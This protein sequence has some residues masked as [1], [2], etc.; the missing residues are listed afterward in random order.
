MAEEKNQERIEKI[1]KL[2]E[3]VRQSEDAPEVLNLG[4][5]KET[6]KEDDLPPEEA[7]LLNDIMNLSSGEE[8]YVP[9][10]EHR[11]DVNRDREADLATFTWSSIFALTNSFFLSNAAGFTGKY[12]KNFSMKE[13]NV[14]TEMIYKELKKD[15]ENARI[16]QVDEEAAKRRIIER[17]QNGTEGDKRR[18][19]ISAALSDTIA[20]TSFPELSEELSKDPVNNAV[21]NVVGVGSNLIKNMGL[22]ILSGGSLYALAAYQ[23]LDSGVSMYNTMAEYK[24]LSNNPE[25]NPAIYG[26]SAGVAASLSIGLSEQFSRLVFN[27]IL[28]KQATSLLT[29][30][31]AGSLRESSEYI[32]EHFIRNAGLVI[33][34]DQEPLDFNTF[35]LATSF[36]MGGVLEVGRNQF[37]LASKKHDQP[38][39][40]IA[41][42]K[43][44]ENVKVLKTKESDSFATKA[45]RELSDQAL[46]RKLKRYMLVQNLP[47]EALEGLQKNAFNNLIKEFDESVDVA[48]IDHAAMLNNLKR[49]NEIDKTLDLEKL[50]EL[51][52]TGMRG[53]KKY[54]VESAMESIAIQNVKNNLGESATNE[55]LLKDTL[56]KELKTSNNGVMKN[57]FDSI[58]KGEFIDN[59]TFFKNVR[60]HIDDL[61]TDMLVKENLKTIFNEGDVSI[62]DKLADTEKRSTMLSTIAK[63][64]DEVISN[65]KRYETFVD[66]FN[67]TN[68]LVAPF[69]R[70]LPSLNEVTKGKTMLNSSEF[71]EIG[72][73]YA[74]LYAR[75]NQEAR[76]VMRESFSDIYTKSST[77]HISRD[78]VS[79]LQQKADM[80]HFLSVD[81]N[82]K[83]TFYD[84]KN[85]IN[86]L[87]PLQTNFSYKTKKFENDYY[88]F[89]KNNNVDESKMVRY[90]DALNEA[91]RMRN[92]LQME[93][94]TLNGLHRSYVATDIARQLNMTDS[95]IIAAHKV[96][97]FNE[98]M[99]NV[100]DMSD[101]HMPA[102]FAEMVTKMPDFDNVSSAFQGATYFP[103]VLSAEGKAKL[104]E[105]YNIDPDMDPI[106]KVWKPRSYNST[107]FEF[108]E[109][110]IDPMESIQVHNIRMVNSVALGSIYKQLNKAK[111]RHLGDKIADSD[112]KVMR[113][114]SYN[115]KSL[116]P[117]A[118][119]D[120]IT[121]QLTAIESQLE[122][123]TAPKENRGTVL[124]AA[125]KVVGFAS[126]AFAKYVTGMPNAVFSIANNAQFVMTLGHNLGYLNVMKQLP[127]ALGASARHLFKQ[128]G[129]KFDV[130]KV[131][132]SELNR[133]EG[134]NTE[135]GDITARYLSE[136]FGAGHIKNHVDILNNKGVYE[137]ALGATKKRST[138]ELRAAQA[139][140]KGSDVIMSTMAA[141]DYGSRVGGLF[142]ASKFADSTLKTYT[143]KIKTSKTLD[144]GLQLRRRLESNLQLDTFGSVVSD[145]LK[146]ELTLGLKNNDLTEF[147]YQYAKA[148]VDIGLFQ[149]GK[150]NRSSFADSLRKRGAAASTIARFRSWG[151]YDRLNNRKFIQNMYNTADSVV[152]VK[153]ALRSGNI[154]SI[155]N[156]TLDLAVSM[157]PLVYASTMLLGSMT[158]KYLFFDELREDNTIRKIYNNYWFGR[159]PGVRTGKMFSQLQNDPFGVGST[160]GKLFSIPIDYS[161]SKLQGKDYK[162]RGFG[163]LSPQKLAKI[164][165]NIDVIEMN[166]QLEIT[167]KKLLEFLDMDSVSP[168]DKQSISDQYRFIKSTGIDKKFIENISKTAKKTIEQISKE[169]KSEKEEE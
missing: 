66:L 111:V 2:A 59:T 30:A 68:D 45:K 139:Y 11:V 36:L 9:A 6:L 105:K 1:D 91:Q 152:R 110:R 75:Y 74:N 76:K 17:Y 133:F 16:M 18:F 155:K 42:K 169:V 158:L 58:T 38:Q 19:A 80:G 166:N 86:G 102:D 106:T 40:R 146:R 149:Y 51:N 70:N 78:Y 25:L 60:D 79:E 21:Y 125:D 61:G 136:S 153:D 120:P 109:F 85:T 167:Q 49:A 64:A 112:G 131:I 129:N 142:A 134:K 8:Y 95:D 147:K 117:E 22:A 144:K 164:P 54:E 87:I 48:N 118:K 52:F 154:E 159:L 44:E 119:N 69:V 23:S 101:T 55:R 135:F 15:A 143:K 5:V 130:G 26:V 72:D 138:I 57:Y 67:T 32:M 14:S 127:G 4:R 41:K 148:N 137:E 116:D 88:R 132:H 63:E 53:K 47:E 27:N 39:Y 145:Q 156:N 121:K 13:T 24:S 128:F 113:M 97:N 43:V 94:V 62:I 115:E 12:A 103:R 33:A 114:R 50:I 65:T 104:K 46:K 96:A 160:M 168:E 3:E 163:G 83:S 77:E 84:L 151:M 165:T 150:L 93:E 34:G 20:M 100:K 108:D 124:N 126:D 10:P 161:A 90:I 37:Y 82:L 162:F 29:R 89:V 122:D 71:Y 99:L 31:S 56:Q 92:D 98:Y 157:R 7:T 107:L 141:S 140:Q 81:P 73:K 28:Q 35:G 123:I